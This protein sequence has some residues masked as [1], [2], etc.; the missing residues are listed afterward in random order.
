MD[1]VRE[2]IGQGKDVFLDLK[3]FDIPETVK[4][5]VAVVA[6]TGVKFLTLHSVASVMR[7][8]SK[9]AVTPN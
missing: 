9:G 2:L 4:R 5:A 1:F 3:L 8:A 6:R 7:A